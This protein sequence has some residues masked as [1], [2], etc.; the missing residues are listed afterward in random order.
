MICQNCNKDRVLSISGK[1]SDM[2]FSKFQDKKTDGYVPY[3]MNIGGGDYLEFEVC[4]DCGQVQGKWPVEF[5]E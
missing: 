4:L 5:D 3:G 2:C 1:T